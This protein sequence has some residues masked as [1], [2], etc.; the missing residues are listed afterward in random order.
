MRADRRPAPV[1]PDDAPETLPVAARTG[2]GYTPRE[3]AHRWRVSP[4][5]IRALVR[6]GELPAL[7]LATTR[8]GRPRLVILPEA[9]AAFERG[10]S[11]ATPPKKPQRRRRVAA[12]VDFY[13]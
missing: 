2:A 13:P 8:G 10:R 11:A 9:V 12:A 6:S 3:L 5:R 4:D 1:P 7:N